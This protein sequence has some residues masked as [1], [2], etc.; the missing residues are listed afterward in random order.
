[1]HY[2]AIYLKM[3]YHFH[4]T[5]SLIINIL[6]KQPVSSPVLVVASYGSYTALKP[7]TFYPGYVGLLGRLQQAKQLLDMQVSTCSILV[8]LI[9]VCFLIILL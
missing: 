3:I 6:T 2:L 8:I 5:L 4:R 9:Q 1:M 7:Y